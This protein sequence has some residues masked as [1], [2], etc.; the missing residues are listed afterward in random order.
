M[1]K[2]HLNTEQRNL[3]VAEF[4]RKQFK[5]EHQRWVKFYEKKIK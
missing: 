4:E 1:D 5:K 3:T 2:L